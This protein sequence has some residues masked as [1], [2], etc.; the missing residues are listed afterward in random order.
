M[1]PGFA[2]AHA[3][4]RA[5]WGPGRGDGRNDKETALDI[6]AHMCLHTLCS[7][8]DK[9][10]EGTVLRLKGDRANRKSVSD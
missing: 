1:V 10:A 3:G 8:A 2:L 4:P 6:S 7:L 5:T 9:L